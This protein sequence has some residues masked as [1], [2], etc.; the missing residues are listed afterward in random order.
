MLFSYS[1]NI[2]GTG[3][4]YANPAAANNASGMMVL[5]FEP[6]YYLWVGMMDERRVAGEHSRT[7]PLVN[8]SYL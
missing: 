3:A 2:H 7:L 5:G 1:L 4:N 6:L 8:G